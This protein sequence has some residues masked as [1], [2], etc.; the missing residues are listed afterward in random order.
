MSN[1]KVLEKIGKQKELISTIRKRQMRFFGHVWRKDGLEKLVTSG[2]IE[3]KRA[4]GRQRITYIDSLRRD[5]SEIKTNTDYIRFTEDRTTWR[6][7]ISKVQHSTS[8][9]G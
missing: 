6:S 7:M 3:G 1:E 2:F 4:R 5:T 9:S 8:Y